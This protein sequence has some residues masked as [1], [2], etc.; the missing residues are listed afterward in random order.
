[1]RFLN[2]TTAKFNPAHGDKLLKKEFRLSIR[3]LLVTLTFVRACIPTMHGLNV[4]DILYLH[5]TISS[6]QKRSFTRKIIWCFLALLFN[7][8][9]NPLIYST[10]HPIFK[11]YFS[12]ICN[13][14]FLQHSVGAVNPQREIAIIFSPQIDR[15]ARSDEHIVKQFVQGTAWSNDEMIES[16]SLYC[17]YLVN[18]YVQRKVNKSRSSQWNSMKYISAGRKPENEV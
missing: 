9:A 2:P 12:N 5:P 3:L 17:D 13:R 14:I 6:R 15:N 16:D 4:M 8:A 18:L 1:M 11:R 10:N 7:V